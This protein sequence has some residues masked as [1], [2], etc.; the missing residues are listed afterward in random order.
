M[1]NG[2]NSGIIYW[3]LNYRKKFIRTLW[4]VPFS[5]VVIIFLFTYSDLPIP[6]KIISTLALIV[7][8]L[9]QLIYTRSKW[10]SEARQ[11]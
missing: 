11:K 9:F 2:H 3:K 10:K 4:M 1:K 5:V 8:L 7:A 6:F